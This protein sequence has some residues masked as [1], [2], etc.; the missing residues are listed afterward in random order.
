MRTDGLCR[1]CHQVERLRWSSTPSSQSWTGTVCWDRRPS[2]SLTWSQRRTPATLTVRI[3]DLCV[4]RVQELHQYEVHGL[5]NN[6]LTPFQSE[7]HILCWTDGSYISSPLSLPPPPAR[8]DRYHHINTYDEDDTND[9]EPVEIRQ[10]SS[11]SPR[12]SKVWLC[13]P[14]AISSFISLLPSLSFHSVFPFSLSRCVNL[15]YFVTQM[16]MGFD[17]EGEKRLRWIKW[18]HT[19]QR[20][21]AGGWTQ[22]SYLEFRKSYWAVVTV[23]NSHHSYSSCLQFLFYA[24]QRLMH[25]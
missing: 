20:A 17:E 9:D 1:L 5:Y 2:S 14:A 25:L 8:S 10:F 15:L 24:T 19:V 16:L 11:C 7:M 13:L 22:V 23:F 6:F 18:G 21:T 4:C 12:F 3:M